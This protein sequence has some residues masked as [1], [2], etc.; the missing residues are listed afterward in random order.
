LYAV[1]GFSNPFKNKMPPYDDEIPKTIVHT[2]TTE[3]KYFFSF[4]KIH[5]NDYFQSFIHNKK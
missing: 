5:P 1:V 4:K 3:D 2:K